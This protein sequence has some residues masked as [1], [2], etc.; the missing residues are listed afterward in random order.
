VIPDPDGPV[1]FCKAAQYLDQTVNKQSSVPDDN[2]LK[3]DLQ[4]LRE[5]GKVPVLKWKAGSVF[6][7]AEKHKGS[8]TSGCPKM[9]F[10]FALFFWLY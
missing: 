9:L 4:T 2:G 3:L 1:W 8:A 10:N 5:V 7:S 6:R